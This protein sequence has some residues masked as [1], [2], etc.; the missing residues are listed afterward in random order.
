M[1]AYWALFSIFALGALFT[2][3]GD[4]HRR[5]T[6]PLIAAMVL[7][8]VFIGLRWEIGPDWPVYR[9]LSA[10]STMMVSGT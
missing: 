8:A 2:H 9:A 4:A 7:L 6:L 5:A 3:G 1:A 10:S